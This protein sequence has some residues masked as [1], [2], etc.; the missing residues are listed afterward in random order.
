MVILKWRHASYK[1]NRMNGQRKDELYSFGKREFWTPFFLFKA[2]S[3]F[4]VQVQLK[5]LLL[6]TVCI[7][8][9]YSI[10]QR[11]LY[12]FCQSV[13][14]SENNQGKG[15]GWNKRQ[16]FPTCWSDILILKGNYQFFTCQID[17]QNKC[18]RT[19]SHAVI[20]IPGASDLFITQL[21]TNNCQRNPAF[22]A[23][24]SEE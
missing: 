14:Q 1:Y 10:W 19:N 17:S 20:T 5:F 11:E 6:A 18:K 7:I 23:Y 15:C 22:L 3:F 13:K 16:M 2:R 4:V 8:K 21:F 9:S 24:I 12:H